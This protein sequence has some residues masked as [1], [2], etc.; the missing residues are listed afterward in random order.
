MDIKCVLT[1]L[2]A[3]RIV[4][5]NFPVVPAVKI[6]ERRIISKLSDYVPIEEPEP[7]PEP[8]EAPASTPAPKPPTRLNETKRHHYFGANNN[9]FASC[10]KFN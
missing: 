4:L 5:G 10:S 1:Q 9:C 6:E 3:A 7:E 2:A 8:E